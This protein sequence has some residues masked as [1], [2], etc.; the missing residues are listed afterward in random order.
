MFWPEGD[1]EG[2]HAAPKNN[3]N[4]GALFDVVSHCC[5]GGRRRAER[6]EYKKSRAENKHRRQHR[7]KAKGSTPG[8]RPPKASEQS[9]LGSLTGGFNEEK[10]AHGWPSYVLQILALRLGLMIPQ[11]SSLTTEQQLLPPLH[12]RNKY[13]QESTLHSALC[14]VHRIQK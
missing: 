10:A 1:N 4:K 5:L 3:E 9:E 13:K 2:N 6:G 7:H 11:F 12:E 8:L 14:Q